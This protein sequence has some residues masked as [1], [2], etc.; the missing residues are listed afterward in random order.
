MPILTKFK[1]LLTSAYARLSPSGLAKIS[2]VVLFAVLLLTMLPAALPDSQVEETRQPPPFD[3]KLPD[4]DETAQPEVFPHLVVVYPER[5]AWGK[6]EAEHVVSKLA[7]AFHAHF[8]T[9]SDREYLSLDAGTLALY[10]AEPTLTVTIGITELTADSYLNI[11][12]R[13]GADGLEITRAGNRIDIL[14]PSYERINE[15]TEKL[16]S[17]VSFSGSYV[18]S[19]DLF[20]L[21]PRPTEGGGFAPDVV[22]DGEVNILTLSHIDSADYTLRALEGIIAHVKPDVVIFNGGVDGGCTTRQELAALWSNISAILAKTDTPWC[23][24]PGTLSG[25]LPRIV[26][27]EVISSFEGCL[28]SFKGDGAVT[29][30]L[31]VANSAGV[32]TASIYVGDVYDTSESLCELIE[33]DAK[34]YDRASDY[35]RAVIAVLPAIPAELSTLEDVCAEYASDKLTDLYDS[36]TAAG[37]DHLVCAADPAHPLVIEHSDGT[38]ALCGSIGFSARG[39]GG[40]FDYNNSIRGGMVLTLTPHRA[41]YTTASSSYSFAADLGLTER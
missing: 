28:R 13:L 32:V 30:S 38:L 11:L 23:F 19:D 22:S 3:S 7:G 9:L 29:Y 35:E 5:E 24:T 2:A 27:C 31:T 8:V 14:S 15:S 20:V 1:N 6:E 16:I 25:A 10:N 26:V 34:L 12:S 17:S 18:I 41:G 39:L 40:R 4:M 33:A 21:D 36:F 37:G